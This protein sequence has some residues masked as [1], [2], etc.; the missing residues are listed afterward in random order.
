MVIS[1]KQAQ[2]E[3]DFVYVVNTLFLQ[4]LESK[5]VSS[6]EAFF[7]ALHNLRAI[8]V[9]TQRTFWQPLW[10]W[11][12]MMSPFHSEKKRL[13]RGLLL[14]V[15][16]YREDALWHHLLNLVRKLQRKDLLAGIYFLLGSQPLTRQEHLEWC[17]LLSEQGKLEESSQV[18]K[19][20]LHRY[21]EDEEGLHLLW[22]VSIERGK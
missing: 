10:I 3:K 9:A 20:F 8:P 15:R 12:C 14:A 19:D 22:K 7:Q 6:T 2:A 1:W 18:L 13:E 4:V 17:Y 21:P 11:E 16:H 5:D